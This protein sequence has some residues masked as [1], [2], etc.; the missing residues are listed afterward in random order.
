MAL[1]CKL[2]T[3]QVRPILLRGSF[4]LFLTL[5]FALS[6]LSAAAP[7]GVIA[8][9]IPALTVT[10]EVEHAYIVNGA[11]ETDQ[12]ASSMTYAATLTNGSSLPSWINLDSKTGVFAVRAP[13]TA[14]GQVLQIRVTATDGSGAKKSADFPIIVD[15]QSLGCTLDANTDRLQR[16]LS[17]STGSVKLRAYSSTGSYQWTGPNGFTSK[18]Q[19]PS[20][21]VPG[22]YILTTGEGGCGRTQA[23]EVYRRGA[24]DD[25]DDCEPEENQIPVAKI[26]ADQFT[27]QAPLTINFDGLLSYDKDGS[28]VDYTWTWA[29]TTATGPTP[30]GTFEAGTHEVVL[31]V[32]DNTGAKSTDYV[33]VQVTNSDYVRYRS[34]WLEAECA[35]VGGKWSVGSSSAAS[36]GSYV[37]SKGTSVSSAPSDVA[38]NRIRFTL[39]NAEAGNYNLFARID[40]ASNT[41]DSYW[42]RVNGKNWIEWSNGIEIGRGFQW[43][44]LTDNLAYLTEGTNTIDFAFREADVRLDKIHLNKQNVRPSGNGEAATNCY[45]AANNPPVAVASASTYS[46]TAPLTVTLDGAAS[47]DDDGKIVDYQW[48]WTGGSAAGASKSATFPA[49]TYKVT[50]TVKDDDGATDTDVVTVTVA[51]A[52][53]SN[54]TGIWLEAECG[55]VGSVWA[56]KKSSSASGEA[57]IVPTGN[58]SYNNAPADES[59]NRVRFTFDSP[60]KGSHKLFARINAPTNGDDSYWV[61]INGGS[62]I[63]WYNGIT[64][65]GGFNWNRLPADAVLVQGTNTID[66]AFRENGAMLDKLFLTSS[67]SA[68]SG[69]GGSATN[70]QQTQSTV[71][72]HWMEAE[73]AQVG[74][75]WEKNASSAASNGNYVVF[76]GNNNTNEPSATDLAEQVRFTAYAQGS[77]TFHLFLRLDAP[78]L[79]SNS[80]WVKVDDGKWMKYWTEIGGN[81]LLTNGFE[82]RKLNNDGKEVSFNLNAGNHTVTI[83][84]R[85]AGTKLDKIAFSLSGSVP[86]GTGGSDTNCSTTSQSMTS[87]MSLTQSTVEATP[88]D[89]AEGVTVYPNP[90]V[91]DINVALSSDYEGEVTMTIIDVNG[92]ELTTSTHTK[93]G[94][95]LSVDFSVRD[96][97]SGMYRVRI[98]EGDNQRVQPFVRL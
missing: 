35:E 76:T 95:Q 27:G 9:N 28:V 22:L 47:R 60:A 67:K 24:S 21:T 73:C 12:D 88:A 29:G 72:T 98:I 51:E 1:A 6:S 64:Q 91:D 42:V 75:G 97:P 92:R 15:D 5:L 63:K 58:N 19:E 20:V 69:L 93:V 82:W 84:N 23:V 41:N 68:P 65:G 56:T 2:R 46:G 59:A 83:A 26:D 11:F 89:L 96:L 3:G 16:V 7:F 13:T 81:N 50:L 87:S 57:Y 44:T 49:G 86:T 34:Y 43:N 8:S 33:T 30:S 53:V 74:T 36:E 80:L 54:A 61:R 45:A 62:W 48:S 38:E 79:G 10:T 52:A 4:T 32:T 39:T 77:G 78:D 37:S 66:F 94:E 71:Y 25:D 40:A 90:A 55:E 14:R 70:C 18:S 31:T 85:E 17:C